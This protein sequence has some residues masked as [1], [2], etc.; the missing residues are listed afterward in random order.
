MK[1]NNV[2]RILLNT[3]RKKTKTKNDLLPLGPVIQICP[4]C[5]KV[6]VYKNDGH[7]CNPDRNNAN[8]EE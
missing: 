4:D 6:D 8:M 3:K 5:G 1:V 7:E 2:D